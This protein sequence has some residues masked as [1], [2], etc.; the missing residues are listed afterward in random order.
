MG[1][2]GARGGALADIESGL[3]RRHLP[4]DCGATT[5]FSYLVFFE[6]GELNNEDSV[7]NM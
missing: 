1:E 7:Y 2:N 5:Y 6:E 3:I 4:N